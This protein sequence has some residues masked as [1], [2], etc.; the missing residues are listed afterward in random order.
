MLIPSL[1]QGSP[2]GK[3][4]LTKGAAS[5]R[6]G[7]IWL[8]IVHEVGW[9]EAVDGNPVHGISDLQLEGF[10]FSLQDLVWTGVRGRQR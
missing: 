9:F 7:D 10:F 5:S 6:E 1:L 2:L 4:A 3:L 8:I